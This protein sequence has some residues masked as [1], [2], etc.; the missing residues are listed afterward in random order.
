MKND[1]SIREEKPMKYRYQYYDNL[2]KKPSCL[3]LKLQFE[4]QSIKICTHF[5][6]ILNNLPKQI[7]SYVTR[8]CVI[9]LH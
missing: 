1:Q 3:E 8:F 4:K 9:C 7:A 2:Y 6:F 5:F